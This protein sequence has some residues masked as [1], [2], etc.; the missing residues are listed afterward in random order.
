MNFSLCTNMSGF[1][2][3]SH[4]YVCI[5]VY[6]V[7]VCVC[8]CVCVHAC[9][10]ACMYVCARVCVYRMNMNIIRLTV[11]VGQHRTNNNS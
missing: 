3:D 9:V 4:I 2:S 6:G 7:C 1:C 8:V 11:N 10:R 5:R